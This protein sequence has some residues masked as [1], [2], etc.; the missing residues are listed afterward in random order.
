MPLTEFLTSG[1]YDGLDVR[2]PSV[3]WCQANI[4]T[5]Y[6]TFRFHWANVH[7]QTYNPEGAVPAENYPLPFK[8]SCFDYVIALSLFTHLRPFATRNYL[9]Q[10]RRVLK[11]AGTAFLTFFLLNN[12]SRELIRDHESLFAFSHSLDFVQVEDAGNPE[13]AIAYDEQFILREFADA[14]LAV[15]DI[16]YG[17]WQ[18]PGPDLQDAI[19]ARPI[20][21]RSW[22][23]PRRLFRRLLSVS[24][25]KSH[26]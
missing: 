1:T 15:L 7:N 17:Q 16:Q 3:Q 13:A 21:G 19:I 20:T 4:T 26:T 10:I 23:K 8:E 12:R 22:L 14:G 25:P 11:P 6:P 9:N 24:Y 2:I 5:Q 18:K